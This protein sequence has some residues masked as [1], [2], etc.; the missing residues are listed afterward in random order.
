M[1]SDGKIWLQTLW[2]LRRE[3]GS[4]VTERL[5]TRAMEL[6]PQ[7]PTFLDMRDAILVADAAYCGSAHHEAIWPVFASRGMGYFATASDTFDI[8]PHADF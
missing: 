1:H 7:A 8:H 5:V 4:R 3:L 6:S 2:Q